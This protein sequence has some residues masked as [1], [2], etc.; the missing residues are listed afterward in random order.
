MR[1]PRLPTPTSTNQ[2]YNPMKNET[3]NTTTADAFTG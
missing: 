2:I 1:R 3:T